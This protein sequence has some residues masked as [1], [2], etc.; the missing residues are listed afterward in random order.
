MKALKTVVRSPLL[1]GVVTLVIYFFYA[2]VLG[3]GLA[4]AAFIVLR[5]HAALIPPGGGPAAF[6]L[7][8]FCVVV[9]ACLFVFLFCSLILIALIVRLFALPVKPGRHPLA[10]P[11]TLCWMVGNGI[12]TIAFRLFLPLVPATFFTTLYF[13]LAG[14]RIGR[15]V[16]LTTVQLLDPHMIEIGDN[17]MVG[18][19]AVITSHL[20]AHETLFIAPIRIGSGCTIGAHALICPGAVIGDGA[21]VGIK[22]LVRVGRRIPEGARFSQAAEHRLMRDA[23]NPPRASKSPFGARRVR[24]A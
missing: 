6:A 7:L 1:Q 13:R 10:S 24:S 20:F 15:N 17:T 18:G 3:A 2:V 23:I 12:H 22:A 9:G 16:W 5:A 19:D 4:P 11:A 14:C 8:S 21:T